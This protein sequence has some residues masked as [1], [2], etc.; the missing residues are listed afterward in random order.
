MWSRVEKYTR[1]EV[2]SML[3]GIISTVVVQSICLLDACIAG[4]IHDCMSTRSLCDMYL[5]VSV[6]VKNKIRLAACF[7]DYAMHLIHALHLW[8]PFSF[9]HDPLS[10]R[11]DHPGVR[12][13]AHS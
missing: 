3:N 4:Q 7:T 2:V 1:C 6:S 10:L 9:V 8:E 12:H 5:Q 11:S 13:D